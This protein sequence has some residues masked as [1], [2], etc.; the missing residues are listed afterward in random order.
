VAAFAPDEGGNVLDLGIG[1]PPP[2]TVQAVR[3]NDDGT[4]SIDPAKAAV[5][6]FYRNVEPAEAERRALRVTT[7]AIFSEPA[8]P[9]AWRTVP[10]TAFVCTED[11]ANSVDRLEQMAD[12]A[13]ADVVRWASSHNPFLSRPSDVATLLADRASSR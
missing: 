7:A 4:M 11:R 2:L 10:S 3:F 8:G 13:D 12:R 9:P 5:D 6:T 1:D